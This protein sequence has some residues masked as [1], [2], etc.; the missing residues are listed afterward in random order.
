MWAHAFE[1]EL[2]VRAVSGALPGLQDQEKS[3]DL[4]RHWKWC[5]S[6][7]LI[8]KPS[9]STL[10]FL[11]APLSRATST[12]CSSKSHETCKKDDIFLGKKRCPSPRTLTLSFNKTLPP[13]GRTSSLQG[14]LGDPWGCV[15]SHQSTVHLRGKRFSDADDIISTSSKLCQK[16]RGGIYGLVRRWENICPETVIMSNNWCFGLIFLSFVFF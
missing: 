3:P 11:R 1:P 14:G 2:S 9:Y 4:E 12:W 7:L 15:P 6:P 13:Q 10:L 16:Q 5:I 8:I